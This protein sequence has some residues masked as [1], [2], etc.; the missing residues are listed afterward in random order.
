MGNNELFQHDAAMA[1]FLQVRGPG[2]YA[3]WPEKK[4]EESRAFSRRGDDVLA[5]PGAA[6]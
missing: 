2:R 3:V 1:D 6:K 5:L 4:P